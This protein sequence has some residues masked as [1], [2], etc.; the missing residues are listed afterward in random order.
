[1]R[2]RVVLMDYVTLVS[3]PKPPSP[4][5]RNRIYGRPLFGSIGCRGFKGLRRRYASL[6]SDS[7][8][9]RFRHSDARCPSTHLS[10]PGDDCST[11]EE[12]SSIV[13][14]TAPGRADK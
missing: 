7:H 11:A 9:D 3:L 1:M 12:E 14:F 13:V 6:A 4:Q 10:F 2:V 5:V 8:F